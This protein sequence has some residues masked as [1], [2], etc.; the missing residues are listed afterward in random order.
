MLF[1][2]LAGVLLIV[3]AVV[4]R[5]GPRFINE[6]STWQ[7]EATLLIAVLSVMLL[8]VDIVLPV[9][10]TVVLVANGTIFGFAAGSVVSTLG[11]T[12]GAMLGYVLGRRGASVTEQFVGS[13]TMHW[14]TAAS[15]GTGCGRS[16]RRGRFPWP[17]RS[18]HSPPEHQQCDVGPTSRHRSLAWPAAS[19]PL[20]LLGA[21]TFGGGTHAVV[22]VAAV[23]AGGALW[24][25]GRVRIRQTSAHGERLEVQ[26]DVGP[27]N[28]ASSCFASETM[29]TAD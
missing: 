15:S 7:A 2:A 19:I 11:L 23:A 1:G 22:A 16:V 27:L 10:S 8:A 5:F 25:G 3:M 20:A 29:D 26:G 24:L 28:E 17:R 18:P 4:E 9:P 13:T 21:G 12:V 6:P 14:L